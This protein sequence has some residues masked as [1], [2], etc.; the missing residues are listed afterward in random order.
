MQDAPRLY[1]SRIIQSYIEYL[2]MHRPE[3]NIDTMLEKA[4]LTRED[5]A[6]TAHWFTQDQVDRFHEVVV[7]ASGDINISRQAGRFGASSRGWNAVKRYVLGFINIETAF[8]SMTKVFPMMTRGATVTVRTLGA[9]SI[10]IISN[11]E[12]GVKEQPYQCENR[13][14]AIEA[15]P[16]LFTNVYA[17]VDHPECLHRGQGQCRYIVSWSKP[18]SLSLKILRNYSLLSLLIM[19]PLL[20][21]SAPF[22]PA[23]GISLGLLLVYGASTMAHA[24]QK[25]REL[26]KIIE[27]QHQMAEEQIESSNTRYNNALLVQEIGQA[28]AAIF[29]TSELMA[30]LAHLMR[31]R[32]DFERGLIMLADE[33][34]SKLTYSAGYGYTQEESQHLQEA[35]FKLD[36]LDSKGIFVRSFLDQSCTVAD[37]MALYARTLSPRSQQ[38]VQDLKVRSLICVPIVFERKSLGILAV[39]NIRPE[40]RLKKSDLNLLQGIASQIAISLNNARSFQKLQESEERYRQT[41][42]SIEEGYFELDMSGNV[43]FV[44]RALSDLLGFSMDELAHSRFTTHFSARTIDQLEI[45]FKAIQQSGK[46]VRFV[47]VDACRKNGNSV[48]VDLSASLMAGPNGQPYGFRGIIRDARDRLQFEEERKKLESELQQAQKMEAMGTL[49]GGIAHNF[50]NWLSGILGNVQLIR[51]DTH[52]NEKLTERIKRIEDIIDNASRMIRQLLGYA[53]GGNYEIKPLK[54]NRIVRDSAETFGT[55]RKEITVVL[56][57]E[58]KLYTARADKSQI[59]QVLWNLYVNAADAMPS[60]GVLTIRTQNTTAGVFK[61]GVPNILP[62]DYVSIS[63]I[64]TGSGIDPQYFGRIFDPFFTTKPNGKGTGLGL[65]SAY[66]IIKAHQGYI[67]LQSAKDVGSTFTLLLPVMDGSLNAVKPKNSAVKTGSET[68]LIVDDEEIVLESTREL[69]TRIGYSVMTASNGEDALKLFKT[70]PYAVD[71]VIIDM[72]M[73]KINGRE[74]NAMLKKIN[75]QVKTLLSSGYTIND[76][77]KSILDLGFQGFIQKPYTLNQLADKIREIIQPEA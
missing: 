15:V 72:I 23:A 31:H 66:G 3:V 32:L 63:V 77:V 49:A 16:K 67:H 34:R 35:Q 27:S 7:A 71:L 46:P 61:D 18:C 25:N 52:E 17:R 39:D 13:L 60:G 5:I 50:N 36:N 37:D 44:N 12:E 19:S 4:G 43:L 74:L 8:I 33:T 58:P 29:K 51:F 70:K 26:E 47:Q 9:N 38:L 14:G 40:M 10:E 24:L 73:P 55:V 48:P 54:L 62:G 57:L 45:V 30:K 6:D 2:G 28:T 65:A 21:W 1:N 41:L 22:I 64:D 59:E 68:I 42:Q 75:P 20:L 11:P 76:K 53:R 56:E 69:L